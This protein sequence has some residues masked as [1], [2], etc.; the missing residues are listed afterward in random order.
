MKAAAKEMSQEEQKAALESMVGQKIVIIN[1]GFTSEAFTQLGSFEQ[2]T[3]PDQMA[4][5][6]GLKRFVDKDRKF[7][8]VIGD[9]LVEGSGES[10]FIIDAVLRIEELR[11]RGEDVYHREIVA[12][13]ATKHQQ[14][15]ANTAEYMEKLRAKS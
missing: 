1:K 9:K 13:M 10:K 3:T 6:D 8:L 2:L 11:G 5:P 12:E 14:D 15:R 4:W 7:V